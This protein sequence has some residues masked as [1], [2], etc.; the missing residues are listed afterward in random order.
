MI[1]GGRR[2]MSWVVNLEEVVEG[3]V[4]S[5]RAVMTLNR[6]QIIKRL[7]DLGLR[8]EDGKALLVVPSLVRKLVRAMVQSRLEERTRSS[9]R[10]ASS[11]MI[12]TSH[13]NAPTKRLSFGKSN[14]EE[15]TRS[16]LTS[17]RCIASTIADADSE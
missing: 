15:V 5:R 3:E 16:L 12:R 10:R 8:L 1:F 7:E 13:R 2:M 17:L 9:I 6:L 11:T 4:I 14:A